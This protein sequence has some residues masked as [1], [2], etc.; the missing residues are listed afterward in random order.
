[1]CIGEVAANTPWFETYKAEFLRMLLFN[2]HETFDQPLA[3]ETF[4]LA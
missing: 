2:D 4:L 3:C 1:M